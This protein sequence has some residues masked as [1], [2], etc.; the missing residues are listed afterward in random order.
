M[1][2]K[3]FCLVILVIA[4][5]ALAT[6]ATAKIWRVDNNLGNAAD[7]RTIQAAHD[8]SASGDTLY[9]SGA[10]ISYGSLFASK[11]TLYLRTRLSPG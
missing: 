3:T 7:W 11:E 2:A 5:C 1:A 4:I 10:A 9:V 6:S 8:G